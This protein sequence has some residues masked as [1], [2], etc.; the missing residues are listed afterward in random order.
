MTAYIDDRAEK[1]RLEAI[2]RE[3]AVAMGVV[4]GE[5]ETYCAVGRSEIARGSQVGRYLTEG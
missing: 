3:R 4:E 1:A 5:P 2:A